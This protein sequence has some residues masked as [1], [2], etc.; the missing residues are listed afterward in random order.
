L[1]G[2]FSKIVISLVDNFKEISRRQTASKSR[3][4]IVSE[5]LVIFWKVH[6]FFRRYVNYLLRT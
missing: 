6:W 4:R 1:R 2:D 5:A 3:F